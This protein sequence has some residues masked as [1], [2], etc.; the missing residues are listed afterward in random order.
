MDNDLRL[1]LDTARALGW[2]VENDILRGGARHMLLRRG[3]EKR[4]LWVLPDGRVN[5]TRATIPAYGTTWASCEE[6]DAAIRVRKWRCDVQST[7]NGWMASLFAF[8]HQPKWAQI[9]AQ[10]QAPTFP[11]AFCLAFCQAVEASGG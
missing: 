5:E 9:I 4:T 1:R 11:A 6:V 3:N 2:I 7:E 8:P 10:V